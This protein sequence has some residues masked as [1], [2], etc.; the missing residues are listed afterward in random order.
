VYHDDAHPATTIIITKASNA[1]TQAG[2]MQ[3]KTQH[4]KQETLGRSGKIMPQISRNERGFNNKH[5]KKILQAKQKNKAV[6]TRT[7]CVTRGLIAGQ[8]AN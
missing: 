6:V 7:P 3:N 8:A 4:S 1:A 5:T 2:Q